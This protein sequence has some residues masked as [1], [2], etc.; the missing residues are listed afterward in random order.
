MEKILE[1]YYKIVAENDRLSIRQKNMQEIL[2]IRPHR[3]DELIIQMIQ[4]F[5]ELVQV[6]Y[7]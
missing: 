3:R 6:Y 1:I 5:P 4:R 7:T 2:I